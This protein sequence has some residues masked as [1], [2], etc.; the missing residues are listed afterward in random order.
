MSR[1]KFKPSWAENH[2]LSF[3]NLFFLFYF[4]LPVLA[5]ILSAYDY[6]LLAYPI[7][8][9]YS[10]LCH[11]LPSH[12]HFI[13]GEQVAMCQRC[14]A[15]YICMFIGGMIF[16]L[17]MVRNRL[18]PL[19][20]RWYLLC[21]IPMGI[22]GGLQFVTEITVV[23]PILV[24]WVIGLIMIGVLS[25]LLYHQNIL[26]WQAI[27]FFLAGPFCLIVVDL[28]GGYK[29]NW[30]MRSL[31]ALIFAIGTI[32]TAYPLLEQDFR[33]RFQPNS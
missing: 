4:G 9:V 3:V 22:D 6:D 15:I 12:S 20:I 8:K 30:Q 18:R 10:F 27:A 11:Q 14:L 1:T 13:L 29:S 21:L 7:Y 16:S 26:Y 24:L 5:P 32:L 17:G 31:T 25:L 23:I 28:S 2:W 19:S 33:H